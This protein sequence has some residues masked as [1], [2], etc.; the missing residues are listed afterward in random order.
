MFQRFGPFTLRE[1][2]CTLERDGVLVPLRRQAFLVLRYLIANRE[3]LVAKQELFDEIWAQARVTDNALSQCMAE[4][5]RALGDDG[6]VQRVIRTRHGVGFQFM[7]EVTAEPEVLAIAAPEPARASVPMILLRPFSIAGNAHLE[8]ELVVEI[9]HELLR[10]LVKRSPIPVTH[11]R[12]SSAP[13]VAGTSGDQSGDLGAALVVEGRVQRF[14]ECVRLRLRLTESATSSAIWAERYDARTGELLTD[15]DV[16]TRS[17]AASISRATIRALSRRYEQRPLE[18][19]DEGELLI[20]SIDQFH[21]R[22]RFAN[23][24]AIEYLTEL[25]ARGSGSLA[26]HAYLGRAHY[27]NIY[28][29]WKDDWAHSIEQ[30]RKAAAE[31]LKMDERNPAGPLLLAISRVFE[32]DGAQAIALAD[33]VVSAWPD[34]PEARCLHAVFLALSGR[35]QDA[36]RSIR[37]A[38]PGKRLEDA[39]GEYAA[40]LSAAYFASE[41]YA[42]AR[43]M[44]R[45]AIID[46]P[47]IFMNHLVNALSSWHLNDHGAAKVELERIRSLRPGFSHRPFVGI[48]ASTPIELRRSFFESLES[49]GLIGV[50]WRGD[51]SAASE[52]LPSSYLRASR[53]LAASHAASAEFGPN[54]GN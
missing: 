31:C 26:A 47:N 2:S 45:R 33:S 41:Q 12:V 23:R 42:C 3:R 14:A 10:R 15:A 49:T 21:K 8:P 54:R 29:L 34:M 9:E 37:D 4:I 18:N 7:A 51:P 11:G 22:D 20:R 32:G 53:A 30:V 35:W 17:A 48:L 27:R 43:K 28:Y 5:R 44:A 50:E 13:L 46:N 25:A 36:I 39:R 40:A 52:T 38:I 24:R 1:S 16:A 19:L 6:T